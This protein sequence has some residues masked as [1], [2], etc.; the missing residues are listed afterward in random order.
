MCLFIYLYTMKNLVKISLLALVV[1]ATCLSTYMYASDCPSVFGSFMCSSTN[2]CNNPGWT[3]I[4]NGVNINNGVMCSSII[5]PTADGILGTVTNGNICGDTDWCTCWATTIVN[6]ATCSI[7]SSD[8][9]SPTFVG[10][11]LSVVNN[12]VTF[13]FTCSEGNVKISCLWSCGSCSLTANTWN[14]SVSFTLSNKTYNDCSLI[15][16]DQAGNVSTSLFIPSFTINYI[17]PSVG[18]T[19]SAAGWTPTCFDNDLVCVNGKYQLKTMGY[20]C[21]GWNLGKSCSNWTGSF[22]VTGALKTLIST[23]PWLTETGFTAL[24]E[25]VKTSQYSQ[26]KEYLAEWIKIKIYVPNYKIPLIKKTILSLNG[27]LIRIISKKLQ[28]VNDPSYIIE[29]YQTIGTDQK[30]AVYKEI[31]EL[32]KT[33]NDFLAVLYMVLDM[34]KKEILPLA[35]YFL[36]TYFTVFVNF[37][38]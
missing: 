8:V 15:G 19:S 12:V 14:N 33:Y 34:N 31:G 37:Q 10:W 38:K 2:L 22:V 17:V 18:W 36:Q 5:D 25:T 28:E 29:N 13:P 20:Y 21:A 6:W 24:L 9:T 27:S 32:T 35:K 23:I 7:V 30:I 1:W 3:C 4:C 11:T 16:Q 26:I